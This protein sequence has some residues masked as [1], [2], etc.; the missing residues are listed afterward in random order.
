MQRFKSP[1]QA[2]QFLSVHEPI[3]NLFHLHRHQKPASDFRA[4]RDQ[5]FS[6]WQEITKL[7]QA[8]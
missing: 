6:I 3:A 8:A 5:A 7:D 2:Q 1:K 4:D